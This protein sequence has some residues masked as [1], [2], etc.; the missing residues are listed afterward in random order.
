M[1]VRIKE[2]RL[3]KGISQKELAERLQIARPYLSQL[4]RGDRSLNSAIKERIADALG[5]DPDELIDHGAH[6]LSSE[7]TLIEAFRSMNVSQQDVWM[8]MARAALR[9]R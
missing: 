6:G 8:D 5:V 2:I 3:E 1:R 9:R 4:E 7:E